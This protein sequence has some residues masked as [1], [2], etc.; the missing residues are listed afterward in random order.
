MTHSLRHLRWAACLLL[1]ACAPRGARRHR[2]AA[3]LDDPVAQLLDRQT[4]LGL[5]GPQVTQLIALHEAMRAK[6]RPI[7]DR[8]HSL[9]PESGH[10]WRDM[11]EVSRE[12]VGTLADMLREIRWRTESTADSMLTADQRQTAA[13]LAMDQASVKSSVWQLQTRLRSP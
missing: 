4:A 9:A 11:S 7:R 5:T 12:S 8:M 13:R 1:A 6:E 2:Q 3:A 10:Q